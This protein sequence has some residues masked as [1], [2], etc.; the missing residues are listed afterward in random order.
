MNLF[1]QSP[2]KEEQETFLRLLDVANVNSLSEKERAI[3]EENLKNYRDWYATIDYAQTE[4]IE[5]GMQ[6][7]MQKGMQK[8]IEKGIEK[9]RQEEKLQIA[10]KMKEQGLDS[11]LIAQCSGLSVED[12]ERLYPESTDSIRSGPLPSTIRR[13][14]PGLLSYIH[15]T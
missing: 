13:K 15:D 12:I 3:Y 11:E 10:Q 4:G 2:F 9:G 1:E 5:K 14:R 8:G 6:E 7:G